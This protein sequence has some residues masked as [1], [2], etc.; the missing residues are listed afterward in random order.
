MSSEVTTVDFQAFV[1][2]RTVAEDGSLV[3]A[4]F[5][6]RKDIPRPTQVIERG[7]TDRHYR[8]CVI[9]HMIKCEWPEIKSQRSSWCCGTCGG[10]FHECLQFPSG[11][12]SVDA[13]NGK[14]PMSVMLL[15]ICQS[16][17]CKIKATQVFSSAMKKSARALDLPRFE[18]N[19]ATQICANCGAIDG[20]SEL[21]KKCARCK[22]TFYCGRE[23]QTA[24]WSTHKVGCLPRSS[25]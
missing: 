19:R 13:T 4:E 17:Q 9:G 23:C 5:S 21:F 8:H 18:P 10:S 3:L 24:H 7:R 12:T 16:A 15:P 22:V 2:H 1:F 14:V 20:D 6:Y 11:L 25:S